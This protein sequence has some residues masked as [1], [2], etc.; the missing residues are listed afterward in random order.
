MD[1]IR[2]SNQKKSKR[3][4]LLIFILFLALVISLG[5]LLGWGLYRCG[6]GIS[7][8][9][10]TVSY[11]AVCFGEAGTKTEADQIGQELQL[12]GGAGYVT[13]NNQVL[14]SIYTSKEQAQNVVRNNPDYAGKVVTINVLAEYK[15]EQKILNSLIQLSIDFDKTQ[16]SAQCI[17]SLDD[18]T[19]L[20]SEL[21]FNRAGFKSYLSRM[22]S[23]VKNMNSNL[24]YGLNY[25]SVSIADFLSA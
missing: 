19:K 10:K 7:P 8:K 6:F 3:G 21:E 9:Q 18:I 14:A 17:K 24:C 5:G 4:S 16:D 1:N 25:L 12:K 23:V 20:A 15:N 2:I 13:D 22:V 11:Y